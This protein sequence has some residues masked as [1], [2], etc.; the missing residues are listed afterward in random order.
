M[1]LD[2]GR[3]EFLDMPTD[4][5]AWPGS[6]RIDARRTMASAVSASPP[7]ATPSE[8][9]QPAGAAVRRAALSA[10]DALERAEASLTALDGRAGDGDLGI[11]MVRGAEA[12]RALPDA[13]WASPATALTQMSH[14]L[15]RAIAGSSG[16]FYATALLRA[17]RELGA[18]DVDAAGWARAFAAAVASIGELGGAKPGDRTMLDALHPASDAFTAA[19]AEGVA[20]QQAWRAAVTAAEAGAAATAE[21]HPRVG[22]AAYLGSRAMGAPDAGAT[23]VVVWMRGLAGIQPTGS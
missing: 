11:S 21:M 9:M 15:R 7:D 1:A 5:P 3:L 20:L 14:A 22:R 13:A 8:T 19:V 17:A 2:D 4:A 10:V 16:P 23:A 6:G 18:E 12:L